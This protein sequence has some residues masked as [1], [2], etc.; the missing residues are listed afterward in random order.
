M[1]GHYNNTIDDMIQGIKLMKYWNRQGRFP[2]E[3]NNHI[4]WDVIKHARKLLTF[5]R[6]IWM[7]KQ[8]SGFCGT[9]V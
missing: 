6:Q 7:T 8:V 2:V 5:D 3:E 4:D 1:L 9:S